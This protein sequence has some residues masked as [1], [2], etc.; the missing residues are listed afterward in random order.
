MQLTTNNTLDNWMKIISF[1]DIVL[2]DVKRYLSKKI[3]SKYPIVKLG[4]C[5]QEQSHRNK[6]S[7]YPEDEFGILG[8]SNKIGVFDAYI[9]KCVHVCGG[10]SNIDGF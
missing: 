3:Q 9:E 1:H 10:V 2:W 8:V 6:L 4:S 5:I 7:D